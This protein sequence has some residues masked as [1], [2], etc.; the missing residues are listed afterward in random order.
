MGIEESG[1]GVRGW[2]WKWLPLD[3]NFLIWGIGIGI[4]SRVGLDR[5]SKQ[6][7][8]RKG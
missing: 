8:L 4:G 3:A 7:L 6:K 1:K 5:M 2:E